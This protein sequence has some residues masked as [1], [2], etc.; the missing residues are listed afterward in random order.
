MAALQQQVATLTALVQQSAS[1][2][3][4]AVAPKAAVAEGKQVSVKTAS[5]ANAAAAAGKSSPVCSEKAKPCH[6]CG[7][8]DH[9]RADCPMEVEMKKLH[10]WLEVLESGTCLYTSRTSRPVS[11]SQS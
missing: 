3:P 6:T 4:A 10:A 8:H 1:A 2:V 7:S 5:V 9:F 11:V